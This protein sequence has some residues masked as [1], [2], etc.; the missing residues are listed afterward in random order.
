M[1]GPAEEGDGTLSEKRGLI[2]RIARALFEETATPE[3]VVRV[4]DVA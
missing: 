3:P 2:P 4:W 1:M